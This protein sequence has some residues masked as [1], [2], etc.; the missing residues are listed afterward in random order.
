MTENSTPAPVGGSVSP[1]YK[2]GDI[3]IFKYEG[4]IRASVTGHQVIN[5]KVWLETRAADISFLV[6]AHHVVGVK[7]KEE[8]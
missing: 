8:V 5:G 3:I 7:P 2:S 4:N 1:L 6:P